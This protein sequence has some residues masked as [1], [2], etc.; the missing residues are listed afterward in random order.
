MKREVEYGR[1]KFLER[2]PKGTSGCAFQKARG[3]IK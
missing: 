3:N 2:A 1:K